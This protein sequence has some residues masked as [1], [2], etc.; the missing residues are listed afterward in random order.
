MKGLKFY[1]SILISS[2]LYPVADDIRGYDPQ[3]EDAVR[4]IWHSRISSALG[5]S[6]FGPSKQ[7]LHIE[8]SL[9]FKGLYYIYRTV[10]LEFKGLYYTYYI[11]QL[12]G[13]IFHLL[14]DDELNYIAVSL[15]LFV[16]HPTAFNVYNKIESE[17]LFRLL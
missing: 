12:F 13:L 4:M 5:Y 9:E 8:L 2:W 10:S 11:K 17:L 7:V 14:C 6:Y 1:S 3:N 15:W 16:V